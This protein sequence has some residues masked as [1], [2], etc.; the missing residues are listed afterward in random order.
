VALAVLAQAGCKKCVEPPKE[1]SFAGPVTK[2]RGVSGHNP[3]DG[4]AGRTGIGGISSVLIQPLIVGGRPVTNRT[5]V[6]ALLIHSPYPIGRIA[7]ALDQAPPGESSTCEPEWRLDLY[8][9]EGPLRILI[10]EKCGTLKIGDRYADYTDE[11][12]GVLEEYLNRSVR[13][14]T[15][16]IVR[17]EVP[18]EVAPKKAVR[19]LRPFVTKLYVPG[20]PYGREPHVKVSTRLRKPLPADLTQLDR[21]AET[22]RQAARDLLKRYAQGLVDSR[23]EVK[24]YEGPYALEESFGRDMRVKYGVTIVFRVGTDALTMRYHCSHLELHIDKAEVPKHYRIDAI[25]PKKTKLSE[26]RQILRQLDLESPA[27]DARRSEEAENEKEADPGPRISLWK[28][29]RS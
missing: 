13:S 10:S 26:V 5:Y 29:T 6:H 12:R 14:P 22:L 3:G 18:V 24:R 17:L 8:R 25:F 20:M 4:G 21:R 27:Q 15:H 23:P 19:A 2:V 7:L 9:L 28:G 16:R 1:H 11:V